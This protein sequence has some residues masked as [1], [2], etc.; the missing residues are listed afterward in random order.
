MKV[1]GQT[2][3]KR[4]VAR[5]YAQALW[6]LA[7]EQKAVEDAHNSL[8][9]MA[10]L[11]KNSAELRLVLEN[12]EIPHEK[13]EALLKKIFENKIPALVYQLLRLLHEKDRLNILEEIC[14]QFHQIYLRENKILEADVLSARGLGKDELEKITGK[15]S[16]RF[17]Q[18][19]VTSAATDP[20]LLGGFRVRVKDDVY[21]YSVKSQLEKFRKQLL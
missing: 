11:I 6:L 19:V 2:R 15:L 21:D 1:S 13:R 10:G 4:K 8:Q 17:G 7:V 12:P 3:V 20:D 18:N 5:R 14:G 16:R 9:N